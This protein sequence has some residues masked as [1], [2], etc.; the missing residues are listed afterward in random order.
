MCD[1]VDLL[2]VGLR[3][4]SG[5]GQSLGCMADLGWVDQSPENVAKLSHQGSSEGAW[6]HR[7]GWRLASGREK[8]KG[9]KQLNAIQ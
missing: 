7:E 6:H 4:L 8:T 9:N 2:A 5:G 3:R 1:T